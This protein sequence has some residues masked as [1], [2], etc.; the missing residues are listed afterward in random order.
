MI[1]R[2]QVDRF[3]DDSWDDVPE[4]R[5]AIGALPPLYLVGFEPSITGGRLTVSAGEASVGGNRLS[6][7]ETLITDSHYVVPKLGSLGY[8]LYLGKYGTYF[9]DIVEPEVNEETRAL[10]HK[11]RDGRYIIYFELDS[12]QDVSIAHKA[13]PSELSAGDLD[14]AVA[15]DQIAQQLG[16]TDYATMITTVAS[17]GSIITSG[18]FL[19][20]DLI[21]T[22]AIIASKIA[23]GAITAAKM[24]AENFFFTKAVGSENQTTPASGD[25]R[26]YLG[27][28]PAGAQADTDPVEISIEEYNGENWET[29]LK[30]GMRS[31]GNVADLFV[32]GFFQAGESV[33]SSPGLIWIER[34]ASFTNG[35]NSVGYGNDVFVAGG[36]DEI[37]RSTDYGLTWTLVTSPFGSSDIITSIG[38]GNDV[39]IAFSQDN[40]YSRSTDYG[41]TWSALTGN[42]FVGTNFV[43]DIA[44]GN[45]VWVIVGDNGSIKRSIDDGATWGSLITNSFGASTLRAVEYY[46]D[47][48]FIAADLSGNVAVST[49]LGVTWSALKTMPTGFSSIFDIAVAH[50]VIVVGDSNGD[51]ALSG[52]GG[53]TWEQVGTDIFGGTFAVTRLLH[54]NNVFV[55][56]GANGGILRSTDGGRTWGGKVYG[57][58]TPQQPW[59]TDAVL[60]GAAVKDL[61]RFVIVGYLSSS[62]TT[63]IIATSDWLEA[64]SG[65]VEQG[66]NTNGNYVV[67]SSGLQ[68]CWGEDIELAGSRTISNQNVGTY[69]W[70]AYVNGGKSMTYPQAFA[71]TPIIVSSSN[72]TAFEIAAPQSP[73]A[74]GFDMRLTSNANGDFPYFYIAIGEAG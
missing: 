67:F 55:A 42:P 58:S 29:R 62:P 1:S 24:N 37:G 15:R 12:D 30:G 3:K 2:D 7:E 6:V 41:A 49:D 23:A 14:N 71:A 46:G 51:I 50:G 21:E 4:R 57:D 54:G 16:Y 25:V 45:D 70:S 39:F 13:L 40:G 59:G 35:L 64:G 43:N 48:T 38:Y 8:Y 74:T 36:V 22:G 10:S 31:G 69:G 18:G 17:D 63:G 11:Y 72:A 61:S 19:R 73:S 9:V 44:Y 52:D 33:L 68:V 60:K 28:D 27:K 56:L 32:S 34:S 26:S 53:D 20:A 66:S 65:I 47:D 5:A